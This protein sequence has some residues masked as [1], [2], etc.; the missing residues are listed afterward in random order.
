MQ[1]LIQQEKH[2]PLQLHVWHLWHQQCWIVLPLLFKSTW[3]PLNLRFIHAM[4]SQD[5]L[6][7]I[8]VCHTFSGLRSFLEAWGKP[9][10]ALDLLSLSFLRDDAVMFRNASW[11]MFLKTYQRFYGPN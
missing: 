8:K 2:K 4:S 9:S 3:K 1:D 5:L 7:A 11:E 6:A 10:V